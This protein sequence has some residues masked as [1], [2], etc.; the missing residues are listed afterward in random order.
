[1]RLS[2]K[3]SPVKEERDAYWEW[4]GR[5]VAAKNYKVADMMAVKSRMKVLRQGKSRE[6]VENAAVARKA[7]APDLVEGESASVIRGLVASLHRVLDEHNLTPDDFVKVNLAAAH[8][9]LNGQRAR[10]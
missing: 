1:A 6:A 3:V 10:R 9:Y 2:E 5:A 4:R 8:R 7:V